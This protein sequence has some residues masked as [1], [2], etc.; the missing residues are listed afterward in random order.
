MIIDYQTGETREMEHQITVHQKGY[1]QFYQ[2]SCGYSTPI[3]ED[4]NHHI[5]KGQV[6]S[7]SK[8]KNE[9]RVWADDRA[10]IYR[11]PAVAAWT[12][13]ARWI[14]EQITLG[15]AYLG[16]HTEKHLRRICEVEDPKPVNPMPEI[17]PGYKVKGSMDWYGVT[18][19]RKNNIDSLIFGFD[20]CGNFCS[21]DGAVRVSAVQEIK[22]RDGE[23]IWNKRA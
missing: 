1:G 6:M 9:A 12:A 22:D 3:I 7:E 21:E 4:I 15:G 2:C 16:G 14:F 8:L 17:L 23:T 11:A 20:S 19:V 18:E 13:C 5:K 10:D